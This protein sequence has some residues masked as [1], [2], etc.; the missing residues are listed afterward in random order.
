MKKRKPSGG[1]LG[2]HYLP[3]ASS[4]CHSL[5]LGESPPPG[6]RGSAAGPELMARESSTAALAPQLLKIWSG[7]P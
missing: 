6:K 4:P 7:D 3:L 2:P 5:E 1:K